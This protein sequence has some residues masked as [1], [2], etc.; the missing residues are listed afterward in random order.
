VT[1]YLGKTIPAN[2]VPHEELGF[3][4]FPGFTGGVCVG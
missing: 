1:T 3:D 4:A 2:G